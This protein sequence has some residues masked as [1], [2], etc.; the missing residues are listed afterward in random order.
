M[1]VIRLITGF[2]IV[3]II[4]VSCS[5]SADEVKMPID[6]TQLF[7]HQEELKHTRFEIDGMVIA[8]P[9]QLL[10]VDT[11]LIINNQF[12]D[13][14][15]TYFYGVFNRNSGLFY[16]L[17]GREGRGPDEFLDNSYMFR[18]PNSSNNIIINNRRLFSVSEI[19]LEKVLSNLSRITVDKIDEL[20]TS[21]S[22][23]SKISDDLLFGT[24]FFSDGRFALSDTTGDLINMSLNYP[25]EGE[26][27]DIS[28]RDLG[29]VFQSS[30]SL[31]PTKPFI[32]V[33]NFTAGNL[34]ILQAENKMIEE[35]SQIHSYPPKFENQSSGTQISVTFDADNKRGYYDIDVTE[36]YIYTL[37]S[38]RDR[39]ATNQSTGNK[40]FV[41]D[42]D[43]N[44]IKQLNLDVEVS[45]LAVSQNNETLYA[46][47][48]N[49]NNEAFIATFSLN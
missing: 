20:N 27:D 5:S 13:E 15:E 37:Y 42:W 12:E 40:I 21:Y 14:N 31:H 47:A 18:A 43:G 34:D 9:Q 10:V 4:T 7:N 17:F 49:D 33:A 3:I 30:F 22:L 2:F 44:P 28:K 19:S 1:I 26:F 38:G 32:A 35:I 48:N 29:M 16:Q 8:A 6:P 25:F 11:L 46:V 36:E 24:G 41:F 39:T 45:K 23:V